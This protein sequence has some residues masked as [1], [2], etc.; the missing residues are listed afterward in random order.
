MNFNLLEETTAAAAG[1]S[2]QWLVM[3][4]YIAIIG[5]ALYFLM[6]RPQKKKQKAEENMRNNVQIGDEIITIGG[7]YGRVISIKE[8][9]LTIESPVDHSKQN[10]A[11]WAVQT[12]LTVHEEPAADKKAVKA[13]SD[14]ADK[15]KKEDKAN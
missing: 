1:G 6:I 5:L 3:I 11:K 14:K 12:N 7:F 8:D 10:I 9:A 4:G 2:T 15:A 13:K